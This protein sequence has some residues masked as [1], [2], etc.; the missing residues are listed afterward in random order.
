MLLQDVEDEMAEQLVKKCPVD[1]F[2]IEDL[3]KGKK[4]F[5]RQRFLL[6]NYLYN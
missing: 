4:Y 1:V 5:S 2:E 6:F 3:G